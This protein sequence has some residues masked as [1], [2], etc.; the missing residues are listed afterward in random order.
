MKYFLIFLSALFV[1]ININAQDNN[2]SRAEIVM[3]SNP[4]DWAVVPVDKEGVIAFAE[5]Q[6]GKLTF[7]RFDTTLT[8][9]FN[10]DCSFNRSLDL[11]KYT[12]YDGYLYLLF[13]G[14]RRTEYQAIRLSVNAGYAER[15]DFYAIKDLDVGDFKAIGNDLY[16]GATT[17]SEPM[18]LHVNLLTKKTRI[19]PSAFKGKTQIQSMEIDKI[20]Q[21]VNV[22]FANNYKN[23]YK[24]IVKSYGREGTETKQLQVSA[25]NDKRLLTGKL[26]S[27]NATDELMIGTYGLRSNGNKEYSQGMYFSKINIGD[28]NPLYTKYYSFTDFKNFFKFQSERQQVRMER[29]I[30]QA[31]SHG[32]DLKLDYRLLVHNVIEKNDQYIVVAEAYYPTYRSNNNYNNVFGSFGGFSGFGFGGFGFGSPYNMGSLY[33]PWGTPYR[34]N[35]VFDGFQYTHAV[36]TGFDKQ[37]NMLWDN[38]IELNDVK[39]FR[40]KEQVKVSF[41]GENVVL[42]YSFRGSLKSKVIRGSQIVEGKTDVPIITEFANDKVRKNETSNVEYWY[43]NYFLVWGFQKIS[44]NSQN[45]QVRGRRNVIYCNKISF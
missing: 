31:K 14:R 4:E 29:K 6:K 24:M 26:S 18:L 10:I 11:I 30:K 34:N 17:R 3:K 37:G 13:G 1:I 25:A 15:F 40:L 21:Q 5:V 8:E 23:D 20:T 12:Y 28:E 16:I 9:Q 19:L 45:D 41:S 2:R 35:Q 32:K 36:I 33:N 42:A 7:T 44:N 38:I 43:D 39:L 27:L 22:A